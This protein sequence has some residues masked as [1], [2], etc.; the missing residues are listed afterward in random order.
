MRLNLKAT[1]ITLTGAI[2]D[3]LEKR[4]RSLDKLI[5]LEDPAV[6]LDVELGRSTNRHQNG[7]LF[8]AEI[9]IHRGKEVFRSVSDRPDLQSAIDD[10]RDEIAGELSAR[11]G[12]LKALSRR[13]GQVAKMLLKGGYESFGYLG[14]PARAGWRYMRKL[15]SRK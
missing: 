10:M 2:K 6:I 13:S 1:N 11:K 9:T 7:D 15:I 12:K 3:Y 8:F 4:L 5:S 14:R